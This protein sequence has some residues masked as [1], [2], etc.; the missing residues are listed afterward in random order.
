MPDDLLDYSQRLMGALSWHGVAMV[1]FK[2]DGNNHWLMEI[3][4]RF[5]GSLPL[6]ICAGVDFPVLLIDMLSGKSVE[7]KYRYNENIYVRNITRD[8]D[9]FKLNFKA[10]K[11]NPRLLTRN[12]CVSLLELFRVFSGRER[13]DH[14][15]LRDRGILYSQISNL[16]SK[17][18]N[19][20]A[21]KLYK[22]LTL[23]YEKFLRPKKVKKAKKILVMCYGN[24]CRSPFVENLLNNEL[25]DNSFSIVSAGFH[26]KIDRNS[27]IEYQ[28]LCIDSG[29]D[30]KQHRSRLITNELVE[31]SDI[32]L[33]MD[34]SNRALLKNNF[35]RPALKKC[36]FLGAFLKRGSIEINDPY[37]L[38]KSD[39]KKIIK[40][41]EDST[42]RFIL[43]L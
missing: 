38:N 3:N 6:A 31:W 25:N 8:I 14:A 32:I 20:I 29:I 1:E 26:Q 42:K 11:S 9:W 10:D 17:E 27:P 23:N 28:Q 7:E 43:F 22:S 34:Y 13:W 19:I 36:Y 12:S 4:G 41:M 33:V 5:W 37:G 21:A 2:S 39:S 40:H 16:I 30:L 18:F 24:I 35:G 15:S